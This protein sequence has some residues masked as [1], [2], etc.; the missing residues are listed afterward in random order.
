MIEQ[1]HNYPKAGATSD[2]G[3]KKEIA[4]NELVALQKNNP[5]YMKAITSLGNYQVR[6]DVEGTRKES[7]KDVSLSGANYGK[8]VAVPLGDKTNLFASLT[9]FS[10][11]PAMVGI[12]YT[13]VEI[14]KDNFK[15]DVTG[16]VGLP[17]LKIVNSYQAKILDN[18]TPAASIAASILYK[19]TGTSLQAIVQPTIG[20]NNTQSYSVFVT[21]PFST[22][23][24]AKN[25]FGR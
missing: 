17:L 3:G 6:L 23:K 2:Q 5:Q 12:S 25:L 20:Q 19:P 18:P 8:A 14:E 15:L 21:Q 22:E 7:G 1:E 11:T 24:L 4:I 16:A 13:P 9:N 10:N